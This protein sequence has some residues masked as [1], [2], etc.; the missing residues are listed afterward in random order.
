MERDLYRQA[1]LA[2]S[3]VPKTDENEEIYNDILDEIK[4]A[5]TPKLFSIS[6][7]RGERERESRRS[8]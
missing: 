4:E 1:D 2:F 6:S 5:G 8:E 7:R 3:K